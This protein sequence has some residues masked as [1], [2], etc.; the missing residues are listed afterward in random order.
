MSISKQEACD[1][2]RDL[3]DRLRSFPVTYQ[4]DTKHL[5]EIAAMIEN[6]FAIP[7]DRIDEALKR[8]RGC[9]TTMRTILTDRTELLAR[10]CDYADI[11][12]DRR[13]TEP[14][15]IIGEIFGHGTNLSEAIFRAYRTETP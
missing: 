12:A 14:A 15:K 4:C 5:I 8:V 1:F 7:D 3:A 11:L 13:R 2:L 10:A 6:D 9:K